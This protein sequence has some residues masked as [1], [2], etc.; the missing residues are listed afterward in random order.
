MKTAGGAVNSEETLK[1]RRQKSRQVSSRFLSPSSNPS[2]ESGIPSPNHTV[3]PLRHKPRTS[4]DTRKHRSLEDGGFIRGLWP[5]SAVTSSTVPSQSSNKIPGSLADHLGNDRLKDLVD[6]QTH[7]NSDKSMPLNRQR[8]CSE[9]SRF[10][11]VREISKEN[12]KP[13]FGGSMRYTGKLRFPGRS[14]ASSSSQSSS[15][16]SDKLISGRLSVDDN[17]L[18]RKGSDSLSDTQDSESECSDMYS[19]TSFDSPVIGKSSSALYMASTASSRKSGREVPSKYMHDLSSKS[20]RVIS[21]SKLPS[22]NSMKK[23]TIKNAMKRASSLTAY[24]SATSKW[25][26][27]PGRSGSPP[28]TVENKGMPMSFSSLKPPSS[29]SRAK[30]VGNLLSIG[31]DLFK[32]K[33]SS[34][35]CS[36]PSGPV[37]TETVHELRMLHNRLMQ[38]RYANARVNSVNGKITNQTESNLLSAWNSLAKLQY[39]VVQKKLKLE[40]EKLEMKLNFMV[41]SQIKPLEAWGEIERQH[42]SA[43]SMTKDC[44]NSVVCKVPFIDGAKVEPQSTSIV[45]R[46]ASDVTDSIKLMLST[47]SP[48][49]EKTALMLSELA[50]VVAQEKALLEECSELSRIVSTLEIQERSLKC[51]ILQLKLWEQ[52]EEHHH[53]QQESFLITA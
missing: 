43:V 47:F 51:Y 53:H 46:R 40:K 27:S 42:L 36:S 24:G 3:S 37:T 14:S 34:S 41:H 12:R 38:W 49:A 32:S 31:L 48:S 35:S 20:Q 22:E 52:Q 39:S 13:L 33:K 21:N 1:L 8:S 15:F 17:A 30:G 18:R 26:L 50:E 16:V 10:E 19:G 4:T 11:N 9:Y 44:L 6:R 5:S 45:L 2:I 28:M 7:Q 23:F 29:P 25:A